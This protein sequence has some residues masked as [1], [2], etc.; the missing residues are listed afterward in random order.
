[1]MDYDL[2]RLNWRS[3]EQLIQGVGSE[4]LGPGLVAFGDG[5]DGGREAAINARLPYPT[6]EDQWSGYTVVQ[7]K[8]SG[9][10]TS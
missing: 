8:A 5:P 9:H 4:T 2:S 10:S 1:M 3:F 7:A 6:G